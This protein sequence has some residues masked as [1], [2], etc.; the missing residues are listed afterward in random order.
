MFHSR[1]IETEYLTFWYVAQIGPHAVM[2][3][4][5]RMPDEIDYVT[6]LLSWEHA[7]W[8][9]DHHGSAQH[10]K[11]LKIAKMLWEETRAAQARSRPL[12][13]RPVLAIAST[14]TG[15]SSSNPSPRSTSSWQ[16]KFPW[17][18]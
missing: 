1:R 10:L 8:Y 12:P 2:E 15:S 4:N 11:V 16:F 17:K 13:Q 7:L 18:R 5:T 6:H 9:L 3:Q 14:S